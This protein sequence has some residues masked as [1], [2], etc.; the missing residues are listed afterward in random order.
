M[1]L[2]RM[3]FI[4][5]NHAAWVFG[6]FLGLQPENAYLIFKTLVLIQNPLA[7]IACWKLAEYL[8]GSVYAASIS[9]LL[10]GLSVTFTAYSSQVMTEVPSIFVLTLALVVHVYGLKSDKLWAI[11]AGAALLGAAVN[12]REAAGFYAPWLI[13]APMVFA[14]RVGRKETVRALLATAVFLLFAVGPFLLLFANNAQYRHDWGVWRYSMQ[15][16]SARHPVTIRNLVPFVSFFFLTS[17]LVFVSLP[18]AMI[19]EWRR[20]KMSPLLALALVGLF[21]NAALILNYST[22][23]NWRYLLTGLP[24]LAPIAGAFLVGILT[25]LFANRARAFAL[26]VGLMAVVTIAEA[27]FWWPPY[28]AYAKERAYA[29]EYRERLAAL[30]DDAVVMAGRMTVAVLYWRSLGTSN[31]TVI[32]T[33]GG[34]P[35]G[36]LIETI[37]G[38]LEEGRRVFLDTD[39]H[40]W[41]AWGWQLFETR[42]VSQL[43]NH[44]RFKRVSETIYEIRPLTDQSANDDPRLNL[45]LPE[46]RT[47]HLDMYLP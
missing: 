42:E 43:Q 4:F 17:P 7:V 3:L 26:S 18:F 32:G 6:S 23:I 40:S 15:I 1:A 14:R 39:R 20:E 12:I 38:Y 11:F 27:F 24:A 45:L 25:K 34:Y 36:R 13:V 10:V 16:E 30:P 37:A 44:F 2:G 41:S 47:D 28:S 5:T 19:S 21:A 29:K 8:T 22:A 31:W 9:A 33:G 35:E 46:N